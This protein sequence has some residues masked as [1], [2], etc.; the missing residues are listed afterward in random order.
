M[1]EG[2][3]IGYFEKR[4]EAR[5]A[6]KE[7]QRRGFRR[8]ALASKTADGN[9][10]TRDPFL[11]RLVFWATAAFI[12]S[13]IVYAPCPCLE[14]G[15][16]HCSSAGKRRTHGTPRLS[17]SLAQGSAMAKYGHGA[18]ICQGDHLR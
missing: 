17:P 15:I 12:V 16:R 1:A 3:L 8:V 18:W 10:Q 7:L 14:F 6:L 5:R 2:I 13:A 9:I 4:D 11:R